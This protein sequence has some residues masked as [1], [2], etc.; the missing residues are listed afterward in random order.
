VALSVVTLISITA[1]IFAWRARAGR[2]TVSPPARFETVGTLA[3]QLSQAVRDALVQELAATRVELLKAQHFAS[4]RVVSVNGNETKNGMAT[5][6][7]AGKAVASILAE[8]QAFLDA[9]EPE[10]ALKCFDAALA[11]Q[12]DHAEIHVKMGG[13]FDKLGQVDDALRCFDRAIAADDSQPVAYLLKGGLFNR[14]ARY[15]EASQCY[16]QAL[17]K[18]K[19]SAA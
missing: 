18:Q 12:P 9:G 3:P 17:R 4:A 10:K 15:E 6:T 13:A 1:V 14:L 16:E 7:R 8:G 19:K 5:E 2:T 11:L